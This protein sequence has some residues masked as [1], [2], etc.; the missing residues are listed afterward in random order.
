MAIPS[1]IN[2]GWLFWEGLMDDIPLI[3]INDPELGD[4][5]VFVTFIPDTFP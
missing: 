4:P 1:T 2:K 5:P 3:V